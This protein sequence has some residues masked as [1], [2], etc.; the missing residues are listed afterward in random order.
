MSSSTLLDTSFL[1]TLVNANRPRHEIAKQFYRHMLQNNVPMYFSVIVA[2]EFGIKQAV[3]DLP[4]G[5]FRILNF[6]VSHG[7]KAADLW[8][9]LGKRDD[10]DSRAVVRDDVKLLA[11]ASHEK[12][13]FILTEDENTLHKYCER[14]RDTGTIQTRSLTLADGFNASLLREDGQKDWV[15]DA[16]DNS[17]E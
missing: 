17:D 9:A 16:P 5:N 13:D 14:L 1:I 2:A 3:S 8:N 15:D 6:N 10:G 4:L 12:I 11:Q 7:Q